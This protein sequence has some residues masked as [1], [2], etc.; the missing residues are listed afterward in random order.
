MSELRWARART[1]PSRAFV[2]KIEAIAPSAGC[3]M[4][5]SSDSVACSPA[6][7]PTMRARRHEHRAAAGADRLAGRSH[8]R[9]A[10]LA[11]NVRSRMAGLLRRARP[12]RRRRR[13]GRVLRPLPQKPRGSSI[14]VRREVCCGRASAPMFS[15]H[16]RQ[17]S[18]AKKIPAEAGIF[19][20]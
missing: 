7:S 20:I 10:G 19:H 2:D 17:P 15:A 18:P 11:T 14:A 1:I 8:R 16:L 6:A 4:P 5:R 13:S 3:C 12:R 9:L